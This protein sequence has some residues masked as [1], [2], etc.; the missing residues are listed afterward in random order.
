ME[1][2]QGKFYQKQIDIDVLEAVKV[3]D[4]ASLGTKIQADKSNR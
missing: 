3:D 1:I 2:T 4:Q